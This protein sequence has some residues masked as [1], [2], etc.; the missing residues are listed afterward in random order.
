MYL[1]LSILE[2]S[3]TLLYEFWYNYIKPK[4]QVNPKP[5]YM[6]TDSI[7]IH[8]KTKDV[9]EGIANDVEKLFDTS[10]YEF[11]IP[12]PIE[13]NKKVIGLMKAEL[14]GKIMTEL[15]VLRPKIHSYL[16]NDGN[17]DKKAKGTKKT[18]NKKK[19]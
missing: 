12:L 7:I 5:C 18:C 13:T 17:S 8:I 11:N 14:G 4:Y 9:H 6:D 1:G 3:K 16:M 10:N 19:T 2:I 15:V